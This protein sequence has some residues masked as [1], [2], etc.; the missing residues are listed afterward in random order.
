MIEEKAGIIS[1]VWGEG[2]GFDSVLLVGLFCDFAIVGMG[3]SEY[4][5][6]TPYAIRV[7][8]GMCVWWWGG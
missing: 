7:Y 5:L 8:N 2:V 4:Q 1:P 3:L 6:C